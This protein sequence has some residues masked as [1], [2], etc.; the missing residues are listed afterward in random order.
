MAHGSANITFAS[1]YKPIRQE[2]FGASVVLDG[3]PY[4]M[5]VVVPVRQK[6]NDKAQDQEI[7]RVWRVLYYHMK[8]IFEAGDT[9]VIDLRK[10]LLPFLITKGGRTVGDIIIEDMP[11]ALEAPKQM[12]FG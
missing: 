11:K 6:A 1:S 2:G 7:R 4:G 10:L 5:K 8:A 12:F 3:K 9:G